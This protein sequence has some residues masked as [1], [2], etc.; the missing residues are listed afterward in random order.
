[1][2]GIAV[3][4]TALLFGLGSLV[5][6][7]TSDR[8]ELAASLSLDTTSAPGGQKFADDIMGSFASTSGVYCD[9]STAIGVVTSGVVL[10][11]ANGPL[12]GAQV[13]LNFSTGD[14]ST[15]TPIGVTSDKRYVVIQP[16]SPPEFGLK[17]G[18]TSQLA[19][20]TELTLL[21]VRGLAAGR[22]IDGL[23][24]VV[25]ASERNRDGTFMTT[26]DVERLPPGMPVIDSAGLLV[27]IVTSDGDGALTL[28]TTGTDISQLKLDPASVA[29]ACPAPE[30]PSE[31][32]EPT[33][34]TDN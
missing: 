29:N 33:E 28:G 32:T 31:S 6:W 19:D 8:P 11:P 5:G 24:L 17:R 23:D 20:G 18:K 1:M 14:S 3:G 30:E 34:S 13:N 7:F 10:L 22:D 2:V 27:A 15:G 26:F 25:A 4:A 9:G 12:T 21:D 16:D